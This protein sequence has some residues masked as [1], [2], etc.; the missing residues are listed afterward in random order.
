LNLSQHF[1]ES[2]SKQLMR[3]GILAMPKRKARSRSSA[4]RRQ[5]PPSEWDVLGRYLKQMTGHDLDRYAHLVAVLKDRFARLD[6][7]EV[8]DRLRFEEGCIGMEM[9][10]RGYDS[11]D[12]YQARSAMAP[13]TSPAGS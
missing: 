3:E 9:H 7:R 2:Y 11:A 4:R 10:R 13:I 5:R 6:N 12:E 8:W 1:F